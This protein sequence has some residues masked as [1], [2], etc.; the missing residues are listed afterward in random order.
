MDTIFI[1]NLTAH[2][3]LGIHPHEQKSPREIRLSVEV[4]LDITDAG[5]QDD[6]NRT[7]N[8]STL[9]KRIISIIETHAFLTI[10]ALAEALAAEILAE[11][12]V[13]GVRL[14]IEK[15]NA[16]PQAESVGVEI[17]RRRQA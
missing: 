15:P 12:P 1:K 10:E 9:A 3:I 5:A 11:W 17:T 8:Y 14:H 2:G 4:F 16:V 6:I 13:E 7:V